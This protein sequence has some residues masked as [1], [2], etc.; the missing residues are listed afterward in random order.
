MVLGTCASYRFAE[1]YCGKTAT[2]APG[3][4]MRKACA[5]GEGLDVDHGMCLPEGVTASMI[6][7]K[8]EDEPKQR[9]SCQYGWL[10]THGSQVSCETGAR[11]CGRGEHWVKAPADAGVPPDL[12]GKC[13]RAA[14]CGSG[15]IFDE[16]G[17]QCVRVLRNG[18]L[19]LGTWARIVLGTDGGEGS[20]ALCAPVRAA[21]AKGRFEIQVTVPDNDVTR[22]SV[23]LSGGGAPPN[24]VDAAEHALA[25]LV[26]TLHFYGVS[27]L[28]ASASLA[29]TCTP[30]QTMPAT[31]E[32]VPEPDA[33]KR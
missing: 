16:I 15:E 10:A 11:S 28:A 20:N 25:E 12:A 9:A 27:S 18:A 31:L 2:V 22:A 6:R 32:P 13:E 33:G 7:A 5:P 30:E 21:G 23:R 24:A 8:R 29:V 19:D 4:C 26:Q 3:G 14:P 17:G 1:E